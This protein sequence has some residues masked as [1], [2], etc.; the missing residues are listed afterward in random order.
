MGILGRLFGSDDAIDNIVDKDNG[1]IAK[2]GGWIDRQQFTSEEKA[3]HHKDLMQLRLKLLDG[4]SQFKVVQRGIVFSVMSAWLFLLVNYVLA[5]WLGLETIKKD[6]ID[7]MFSA[8][9]TVPA[10]GVV[11]LYLGGGTFESNNRKQG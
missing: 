7:L 8:Y 4:L 11:A 2:A 6:L 3:E 5:V 10:G 1:L 9:M